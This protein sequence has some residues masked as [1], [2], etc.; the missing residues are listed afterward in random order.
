MRT[1]VTPAPQEIEQTYRKLLQLVIGLV[2]RHLITQKVAPQY[3]TCLY[4]LHCFLMKKITKATQFAEG[5][6]ETHKTP[7]L[8]VCSYARD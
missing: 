5:F 3:L 7:V 2:K 4:K 6:Y 8:K 1:A